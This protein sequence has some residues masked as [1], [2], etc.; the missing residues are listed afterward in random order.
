MSANSLS[1]EDKL[2]AFWFLG[3][4][5]YLNALSDKPIYVSQIS[6]YFGFED[7]ITNKIVDYLITCG[8]VDY[9]GD[10]IVFDALGY[11]SSSQRAV[12]ITEKGMRAVSKPSSTD[13]EQTDC[14]VPSYVKRFYS[15]IPADLTYESI[16][17]AS[18]TSFH[19]TST[20]CNREI[21]AQ[22][23]GL[24]QGAVQA[25]KGLFEVIG[26][27]R[28]SVGERRLLKELA[29]DLASQN[30]GEKEAK[31]IKDRLVGFLKRFSEDAIAGVVIHIILSFVCCFLPW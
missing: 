17:G 12:L 26:D 9:S 1:A 20:C 15:C 7:S 2:R 24:F 21:P 28:L 18:V 3:Y 27:E 11:R 16:S 8:F 30:L 23:D 14:V 10:L 6:G 13:D 25:F 4:L 31:R 5:D 29:S 22:T 19:L